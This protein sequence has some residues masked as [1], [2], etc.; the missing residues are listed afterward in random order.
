MNQTLAVW[1][2][3]ALALVSANLPFLTERVF[4]VLPWKQGGAAA[5]KPFW[6]RLVEV[7]VFYAIVG[8][9]GFAFESAL[10]NRFAQT[11]EFYAITLSLFLVLAYPGF[12]Y[13]Y[14]FKRHPRLRA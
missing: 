8:A 1:L 12:V 3:I 10:G 5:P 6:L 7:L 2:L 14:L 13:R 4:A 11:W 9:L